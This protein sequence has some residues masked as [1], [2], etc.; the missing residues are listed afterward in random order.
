MVNPVLVSKAAKLA[1]SKGG[2]SKMM[3][4]AAKGQMGAARVAAARQAR[5]VANRCRANPEAC[6]AQALGAAKFVGNMR[7]A[8]SG[9]PQPAPAAQ[10]APATGGNNAQAA[11]IGRAVMAASARAKGGMAIKGGRYYLHKGEKVVSKR[12]VPKVTKAMKKA[13]MRVR[14]KGKA[15]VKKVPF[16]PLSKLRKMGKGGTVL[17]TGVHVLKPGQRIIPAS[18]ATKAKAAI[19]KYS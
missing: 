1:A 15:T 3:A 13:G 10:S 18:K 16:V 9:Q 12:S 8:A 14:H 6:K 7:T 19:K 4:S 2:A 11:A 17:K 5:A